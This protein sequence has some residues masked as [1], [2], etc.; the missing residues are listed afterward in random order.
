MI[1]QMHK[2]GFACSLDDFGFGYSSLGLLSKLEVDTIKLDKIFFT[3]DA[4]SEAV[5]ESMV[6]LCR[7]LKIET[8]A[9]GIE[10]PAQPVSYTHL[11]LFGEIRYGDS[12]LRQLRYGR[13]YRRL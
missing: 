1:K 6:A 4:R 5:V 7:K 11:H 9:E 10:S 3:G 12:E 2:T 13:T 8:V